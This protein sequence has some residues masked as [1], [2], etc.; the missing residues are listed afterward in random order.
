MQVH[1]GC[2]SWHC[3]HY[4]PLRA[5]CV[6]RQHP[7]GLST[8]T[9]SGTPAARRIGPERD[10]HHLLPLYGRLWAHTGLIVSGSPVQG[11][12]SGHGCWIFMQYEWCVVHVWLVR[13]RSVR[14]C[15]VSP[16]STC[17]ELPPYQHDAGLHQH[18][19]CNKYKDQSK[20]FA[21]FER[22]V[23]VAADLTDQL[24]FRIDR[25]IV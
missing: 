4:L 18:A 9:A 5:L 24:Q 19:H 11:D 12:L 8:T 15:R 13:T 22:T 6:V 23:C 7:C 14:I 16:S 2:L 20:W 17:S 10:G 1:L 21:S 3:Y 25:E